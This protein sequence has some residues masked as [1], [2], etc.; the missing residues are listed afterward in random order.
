MVSAPNGIHIFALNSPI[1]PNS[2]FILRREAEFTRAHPTNI[3]ERTHRPLSRSRSLLPA[4]LASVSFGFV[5]GRVRV[6]VRVNTSTVRRTSPQNSSEKC[7]VDLG[8]DSRT[9]T[10]SRRLVRRKDA[11]WCL[12]WPSGAKLLARKQHMY[13]FWCL[14]DYCVF[15]FL[16]SPPPEG[17][18]DFV[19]NRQGAI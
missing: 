13:F 7:L 3:P 1:S 11:S 16:L 17:G 5:L 18:L 19:T 6:R 4:A 10:Q 14:C 8:R 9:S 15:F 2:N 12:N